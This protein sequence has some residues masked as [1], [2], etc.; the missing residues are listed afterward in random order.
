MKKL[1]TILLAVLI[2]AGVYSQVPFG[3]VIDID[4]NAYKTV[5]IGSQVWMAENLRVTHYKNGDALRNVEDFN[6]TDSSWRYI[7]KGAYCVYNNDPTN[8]P[9]Y[10]NLYNYRAAVDERGLAPEG[11]HVAKQ[12]DWA[13]LFQFLNPE[14]GADTV[15]YYAGIQ[16]KEAGTEY[17]NTTTPAVTNPWGWSGR[18]AGYRTSSFGGLKVYSYLMRIPPP[19]VIVDPSDLVNKVPILIG[20][21]EG[22]S[23]RYE[24]SNQLFGGWGVRCVKN[25]TIF[26]PTRIKELST[27]HS[28]SVYPNPT[29][30]SLKLRIENYDIKNL[31]YHIYAINGTFI[32]SNKVV[33]NET[34]VSIEKFV[35]GVYFMKVTDNNKVVKTFKI[36]KN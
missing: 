11:W 1:F 32:Q 29:S 36:I 4:S 12:E 26:I 22:Q 28:F 3:T 34:L 16:L 7:T 30:G 13:T 31:K 33:N 25:D 10:G 20:M 2:T 14:M 35:P 8:A 21:H 6:S 18:G 23:M 17:W 19:E 24:I 27:N 5:K 15:H 9:I